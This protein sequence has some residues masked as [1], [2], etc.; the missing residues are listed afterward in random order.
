MYYLVD[1]N[2][3]L[4]AICDEIYT[5]ANLCKENNITLTL[6]TPSLYD[7]DASFEN[8]ELKTEITAPGEIEIIK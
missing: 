4:H 3:F 7:D 2:V 1:T 5:V 6:V 8:G